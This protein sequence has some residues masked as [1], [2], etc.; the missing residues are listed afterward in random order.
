MAVPLP[1]SLEAF[2]DA[3]NQ[4]LPSVHK[5]TL[6]DA[7]IASKLVRK[8]IQREELKRRCANPSAWLTF[9]FERLALPAT[10]DAALRAL[11]GMVEGSLVNLDS[12]IVNRMRKARSA[13][14]QSQIDRLRWEIEGLTDLRRELGSSALPEVGP[15]LFLWCK[16]PNARD[17][18]SAVDKAILDQRSDAGVDSNEPQNAYLQSDLGE[19]LSPSSDVLG[20][21]K[22]L[23]TREFNLGPSWEPGE[24]ISSIEQRIPKPAW[25]ETAGLTKM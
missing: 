5:N 24:V 25:P 7:L 6:Q 9:V 14:E 1:Y 15:T 8:D 11:S 10:Q 2:R 4:L 22:V 20:S 17:Q 3:A 19:S 21:I 13:A 23:L 18:I 12:R 16:A